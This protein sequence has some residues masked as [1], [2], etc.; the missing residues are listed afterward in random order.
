MHAI[1]ST[2][3]P[4][5]SLGLLSRGMLQRTASPTATDGDGRLGATGARVTFGV[6]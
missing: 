3:S 5:C 1:R 4:T 2:A 6:P